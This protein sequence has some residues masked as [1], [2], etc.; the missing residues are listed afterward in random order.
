MSCSCTYLLSQQFKFVGPGLY[1]GQSVADLSGLLSHA[2]GSFCDGG[3]SAISQLL[4]LDIQRRQVGAALQ[5]RCWETGGEQRQNGTSFTSVNTQTEI[6]LNNYTVG[7]TTC[8]RD[9]LGSCG[10]LLH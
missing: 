5:L 4:D 9:S 1:V 10:F 7:L 3:Q 6:I 2:S 8:D